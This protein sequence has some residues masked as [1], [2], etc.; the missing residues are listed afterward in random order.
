MKGIVFNIQ[1]FAIHDGPGIRTTVFLKGC[2]L[3]CLWCQNPESI[4]PQMEIVFIADKC[5]RCG[6]CVDVCQNQAVKF[7]D[8]E[9]VY[10]VEKCKMCGECSRHCPREAVRFVGAGMDSKEVV[11]ILERDVP[12]YE[13]SGGGITISGGE[14]L[15]QPQFTKEIL[16]L[17]H[18]KG[19][20]TVL[21]TSAYGKWDDIEQLLPYT[22][23]FL[24]DI[25][26]VA[27]KRHIELTGVDNKLIIDNILRLSKTHTEI[28]IRVPVLPGINDDEKNIGEIASLLKDINILKVELLPYNRL[29]EAK[30]KQYRLTY[31]LP[32]IQTPGVEHMRLIEQYLASSGLPVETIWGLGVSL[33]TSG[34]AYVEKR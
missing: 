34:G 11:S 12:F 31:F 22:D 24:L 27:Q 8:N 10:Q 15:F 20:H 32:Y 3:R 23:L 29:A 7:T 21:D 18:E 16:Q 9:R 33:Q 28:I 19:I 6:V 17:S 14:P 5:I 26:I 30:Y 13:T 1:R 4:N 25:K 2:P